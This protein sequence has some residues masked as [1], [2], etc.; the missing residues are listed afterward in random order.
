MPKDSN[1][2]LIESIEIVMTF[3]EDCLKEFR[4]KK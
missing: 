3:L 4:K 2:K 1:E